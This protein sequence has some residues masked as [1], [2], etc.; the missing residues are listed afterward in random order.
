MANLAITSVEKGSAFQAAIQYGIRAT[1]TANIE[2][3]SDIFEPAAPVTQTPQLKPIGARAI[4]PAPAPKSASPVH[5]SISKNKTTY[6][7]N[8]TQDRVL[9]MSDGTDAT[10]QLMFIP[11]ALT[12]DKTDCQ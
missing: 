11:S 5:L 9:A 6:I 8:Y 2:N 7:Q 10:I 3:F 12:P 1:P 4:A